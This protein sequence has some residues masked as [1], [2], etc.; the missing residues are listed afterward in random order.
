M[1]NRFISCLLVSLTTGTLFL[2]A[3]PQETKYEPIEIIETTPIIPDAVT[4]AEESVRYTK[5]WDENCEDNTIKIT[6][7]DAQLLMMVAQAESGNQGIEGMQK[8]MEVILNR[9]VSEDFPNTVQEVIYQS[10]Q[11]ESVTN[12][13]IYKAEISA[14]CH[15][16]LAEVE[17]NLEADNSI[18][19]FETSVNGHALSKYFDY[20]YTIGSHDFYTIKED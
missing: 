20:V 15:L 13:S 11:F 7:A 4:L 14:E 6:Y 8:V 16:A 3:T 5:H 1:L 17:K 18:I 9:V 19:A 12:G 2:G 10:G